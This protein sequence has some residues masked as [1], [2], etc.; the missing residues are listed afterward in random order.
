MAH[1]DGG[2]LRRAL[3]RVAAALFM[4]VGLTPAALADDALVDA[5][6]QGGL[7]VLVRHAVTVPGLGDPPEF[8]LGDC[9]TQRNLSDAGREQARALGRWFRDQGIAV[10]EVRSSRWCRCLETATLAFGE[11]HAVSPWPPLDSFFEARDR[12]SSATAAALAGLAQPVAGNRVWVT[13]QVNITALSGV[14]PASG[15]MVVMRPTRAAGGGW[16]LELVGRLRPA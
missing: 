11:N 4:L 15:E 8:R 1:R 13:H 14:F 9:T 10:G 6:R 5:L 2:R 16:Q 3:M 7:V 12:E